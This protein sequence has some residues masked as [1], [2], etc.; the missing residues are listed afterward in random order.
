MNENQVQ[1]E[2][3]KKEFAVNGIEEDTL[4]E[5]Q[6]IKDGLKFNPKADM[7]YV[8][9]MVVAFL[10]IFVPPIFRVVFYDPAKEI[11][12]VDVVHLNLECRKGIYR[13]GRLFNTKIY[14]K[15]KN[16]EVL[17][18]TF[19]YTWAELKEDEV[20][21]EAEDFMSI[22]SP[23]FKYEKIV[24]GYK[25]TMDFSDKNLFT[26]PE[27]ADYKHAAPAQMNYYKDKGFICESE[28]TTE[29]VEMT[30]DELDKQN[31]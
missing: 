22:E 19:E 25:F 8:I 17:S 3:E 31:K 5:D 16:G 1:N 30:R 29:R 23:G 11:V 9:F 18:S 7:V 6:I 14:S 24:D 2:N 15:Y 13:G 12:E 28:S 20:I 4:S 26:I 21:P 10:M 27:L